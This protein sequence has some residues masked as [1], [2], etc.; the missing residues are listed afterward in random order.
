MSKSFLD[1]F[2]ERLITWHEAEGR[3]G[4]PWQG[5]HDAYAV[6]VSEI[7]LQQT[8]VETVRA[9]YARWIRALPTLAALARPR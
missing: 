7:M 5:K 9:Y 1:Q 2:A 8:R 4:L 3:H 6:W